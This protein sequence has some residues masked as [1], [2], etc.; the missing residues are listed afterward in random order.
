MSHDDIAHWLVAK[1]VTP[2][3]LIGAYFDVASDHFSQEV[4]GE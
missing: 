4:N 1:P 2:H 3:R